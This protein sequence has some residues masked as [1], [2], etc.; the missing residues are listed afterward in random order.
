MK[1]IIQN[2]KELELA[3]SYA[4]MLKDISAHI[5]EDLIKGAIK[6]NELTALMTDMICLLDDTSMSILNDK[7]VSAEEVLSEIE[8][9][10]FYFNEMVKDYHHHQNM[11]R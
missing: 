11:I 2:H 9:Y 10:N 7:L 5:A 1:T 6:D 3:R 4:T 8:D